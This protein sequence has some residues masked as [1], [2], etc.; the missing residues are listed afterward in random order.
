MLLNKKGDTVKDNGNEYIIGMTINCSENSNY[1]GVGGYILEIRD[2]NDKE[3][4]N[5]TIEIVCNLNPPADAAII[6]KLEKKFSEL[7]RKPMKIADINL[8]YVVLSPDMIDIPGESSGENIGIVSELESPEENEEQ[9]NFDV[10]EDSTEKNDETDA[11]T[12]AADI[13]GNNKKEEKTEILKK[14]EHDEAEAKRK[15]EWEAEQKSKKAAEEKALEKWRSMSDDD[16]NSGSIKKL[17]DG[18]ERLTR[19]NMKTCVTEH[20]EGLCLKNPEFARNVMHPSK[21]LINC[22][23]YINEKAMEY[24]KQ[25]LEIR[26]EKASGTVGEDVPDDLCYQWAVDYFNDINAK[27]DK[28]KEEK[29]VPKT[30]QG[31]SSATNG[32][33]KDTAKPKPEVSKRKSDCDG[34]QVDIFGEEGAA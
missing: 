32:Y 20:I 9:E 17:G 14:K 15:A 18:L 22:F 33:K 2:G 24:V 19:R 30:Y 16:V 7:F 13:S 31:N 21:N 26:G 8:S 10:S 3:M 11:E 25:E 28:E 1:P 12:K 23:K 27:V 29:F 6:S 5:D 4:D 34:E